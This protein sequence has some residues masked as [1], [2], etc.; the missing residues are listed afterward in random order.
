[1]SVAK[2][3]YI[4]RSNLPPEQQC[5]LCGAAIDLRAC[6]SA[7]VHIFKDE[8]LLQC[9]EL[10]LDPTITIRHTIEQLIGVQV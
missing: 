3:K 2:R 6:G 5:R 4:R 8:P 1:M 9:F 10:N 7:S